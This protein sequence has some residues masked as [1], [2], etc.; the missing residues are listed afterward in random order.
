MTAPIVTPITM[1]TL[2]IA[3]NNMLRSP[4]WNRIS[5]GAYRYADGMKMLLYI[6]LPEGFTRGP[7]GCYHRFYL[8]ML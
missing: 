6:W 7:V 2:G 5:P 4:L 1:L 8:D 3:R